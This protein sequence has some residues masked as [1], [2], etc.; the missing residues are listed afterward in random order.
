ML[1]ALP[2]QAQQRLEEDPVARAIAAALGRKTVPKAAQNPPGSAES[3]SAADRG[4]LADDMQTGMR[5]G[6]QGTK[7]E[8]PSHGDHDP[9]SIAKRGRGDIDAQSDPGDFN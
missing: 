5:E 3:N 4:P 9:S 6:K 7:R 1:W 8:C 2:C